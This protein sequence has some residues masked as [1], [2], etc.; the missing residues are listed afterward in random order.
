R[1]NDNVSVPAVQISSKTS[2]SR[3]AFAANLIEHAANSVLQRLLIVF[4]GR[5]TALDKGYRHEQTPEIRR[6]DFPFP[7]HKSQKI[8]LFNTLILERFGLTTD[9]VHENYC[10]STEI[11]HLHRFIRIVTTVLVTNKKHCSIHPA[12][13]E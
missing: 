12:F 10:C 11:T 5:F 13:N 8:P 4:G 9:S 2:H 7:R 1:V 6:L 3:L